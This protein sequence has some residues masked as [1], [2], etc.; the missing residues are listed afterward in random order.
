MQD[1]VLER[2]TMHREV[3]LRICKKILFNYPAESFP[4]S[5]HVRKV[6]K[7][8]EKKN[9]PKV[10]EQSLEL[11]QGQDGACSHESKCKTS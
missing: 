7:A 3:K 4:Q 10:L 2:R 9:Y 6:P 11:T 5:M 1:R 8:K